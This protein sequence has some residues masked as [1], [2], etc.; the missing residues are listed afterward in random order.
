M[1]AK[2]LDIPPETPFQFLQFQV[3]LTSQTKSFRGLKGTRPPD[4]W[5]S[6]FRYYAHD[7]M[8]SPTKFYHA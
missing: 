6:I 3:I 7:M 1:V 8:L 2:F 4:P 5:A